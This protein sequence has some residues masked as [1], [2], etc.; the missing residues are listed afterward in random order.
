[1]TEPGQVSLLPYSRVV[2]QDDLR[3]LLEIAFVMGPKDGGLL[4][5]GERGSAKSTIVRSF[6]A[7]MYDGH[8]PV[9]LP[10]NAT[11]DRIV[12]GWDINTLIG[13]QLKPQPGLLE[14]ANGKM[15]YIDEVNLLDNHVVNLILDVVSTGVL[16]VEREGIDYSQV[17]VSFLLVGTMNP[18]EGMLRPPLLDRF[19]LF[20]P[21]A[22]KQD[23]DTR[24]R[25]LENVLTFDVERDNDYSE[26]L[27]VAR[28]E[29]SQTKLKL[30]GARNAIAGSGAVDSEVLDVCVRV[31]EE[32]E[33]VG[34]RAGIVMARA[35][36]A[37]AAI[38]GRP[39]ATPAD[40]ARIAPYAVRHRRFNSTDDLGW[41]PEDGLR[42]MNVIRGG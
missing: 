28:W 29:D 10:I 25:I 39:Y 27:E 21:V 12:G 26:W 33:V 8:L 34:H 1:M 17:D 20:A 40:V 7:M 42:L 13:G 5:S 6:A 38:A 36:R 23:H 14:Q 32:F 24:L 37:V 18:E 35:A 2:G 11:D 31:T 15:L 41:T 30:D 22:A 19:P 9:T 16:V 4:I 3:D